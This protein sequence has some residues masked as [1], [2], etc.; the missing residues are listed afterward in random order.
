MNDA[1]YR[2]FLNLL[3]TSEIDDDDN[4]ILLRQMANKEAILRG[5]PDWLDAY[6][7]LPSIALKF[8]R[9]WHNHGSGILPLTS[10]DMETH[11]RRVA[12]AA[13]KSAVESPQ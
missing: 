6:E 12:E 9:W 7:Q 4:Y 11:A 5:Y 1:E 2:A 10:D 13:W 3:M 8:D